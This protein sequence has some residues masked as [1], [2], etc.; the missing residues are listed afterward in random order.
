MKKKHIIFDLDGTLSDTAR[1]TSA[2]V[3]EARDIH[4]FPNVNYDSIL[5]AM[6]LPGLEFYS[7]LYPNV[8]EKELLQ[9]EKLVDDAEERAILSLGRDILFPGVYD[10]LSKLHEYGYRLYIAS[11][12][13]KP[14]VDTTLD[15]TGI[16]FLFSQVH[17][18]KPEKI[19]MVR[20]IILG[21]PP[22][23]WAMVG[24]MYK[25]SEAARANNILALGAG[26]G[27]LAEKDISLFDYVLTK[28]ADIYTHL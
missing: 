14:H 28:P 9:I 24:D 11:T 3:T 12:G 19:S 13:G 22:D 17:C 1:A 5:D 7:H 20:D 23:E 6:G 21:Q 10:M 15:A 18:G 8:S 2:A 27:Y 26:F 16:R 4:G 25:D